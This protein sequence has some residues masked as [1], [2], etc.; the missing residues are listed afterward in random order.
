LLSPSQSP[1]AASASCTSACRAAQC[2]LS[3]DSSAFTNAG[4]HELFTCA[5]VPYRYKLTATSLY[6][7]VTTGNTTEGVLAQLQRLAKHSL[8]PDTIEFIERHTR[9]VGKLE[10]VEADSGTSIAVHDEA[11]ARRMMEGELWSRLQQLGLEVAAG[12]EHGLAA[13]DADWQREFDEDR[14]SGPACHSSTFV[15]HVTVADNV[16]R[17]RKTLLECASP[18]LLHTRHTTSHPQS[19]PYLLSQLQLQCH[20]RLRFQ[21]RYLSQTRL[22]AASFQNK[23]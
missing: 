16:T 8:Q 18:L 23:P 7:A 14:I 1:S 20:Q 22:H 15:F 21:A 19:L 2:A 11:I 12:E 13:C 4:T 10:L 5:Q 6:S 9:N 3:S 17:I